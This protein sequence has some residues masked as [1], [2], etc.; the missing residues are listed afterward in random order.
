MLAATTIWLFM[1]LHGAVGERPN[2]QILFKTTSST[3]CQKQ[4]DDWNKTLAADKLRAVCVPHL[5]KAF[6]GAVDTM[7]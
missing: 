2:V 6:E 7:E 4:A 1:I 5:Q 3:T